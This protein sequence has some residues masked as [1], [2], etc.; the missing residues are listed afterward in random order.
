MSHLSPPAVVSRPAPS[1][2]GA[3]MRLLVCVLG[4]LGAGAIGGLA[5]YPRI[6]TWYA[7][8]SKPAWTPPDALFGP[9]WSALYLLMAIAVWLVWLRAS[10]PG[11]ATAIAL[12]LF[13]LQL[14]LNV[15]WPVLFFGLGEVGL[16]A[17]ELALLWAAIAAT[18][19]AFARVRQTAA[20]LLAP[21][22]AWVTFALFL[23]LAIWKA[24]V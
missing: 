24:N 14:G 7:A 16:A 10:T 4:C 5:T 22:L 12:R 13:L 6:D 1:V 8:L 18:T 21:Y 23:N 17:G 3:G 11:S 20:W 15:V 19:V 2:F 9:V